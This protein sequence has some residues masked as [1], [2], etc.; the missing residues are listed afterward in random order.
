MAVSQCRGSSPRHLR[1]PRH[2][3]GLLGSRQRYGR[4]KRL[5]QPGR[6]LVADQW[7]KRLCTNGA[8][9]NFRRS[10]DQLQNPAAKGWRQGNQS[11]TLLHGLCSAHFALR[12]LKFWRAAVLFGGR[13]IGAG[14]FHDQVQVTIAIVISQ[15]AKPSRAFL[16]ACSLRCRN[17]RPS[18]PFCSN[19]VTQ[20]VILP[21]IPVWSGS[22]T[23]SNR[24]AMTA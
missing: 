8:Q 1:R 2:N 12:C 5:W 14:L 19:G 20:I 9:L 21:S 13:Q 18:I 10:S 24:S 7:L 23:F 3:P 16:P 22:R 11:W 15:S 17:R 6:G 4:R